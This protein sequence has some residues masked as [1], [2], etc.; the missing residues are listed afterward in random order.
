MKP[1]EIVDRLFEADKSIRYVAVVGPAP[2][3]ELLESRMRE[4]LKS[5]TE[6]KTDRDFVGII[7][8]V[9]LGAS[10]RLEKDLGEVILCTMRYEKATLAF[11]RLKEYI[12]TLGLEP[13]VYVLPIVQRIK[14]ELEPSH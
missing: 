12:V 3:Y 2:N 4:G 8:V 1:S 9:M 5:L 6:E 10:E 14:S 11:F 7:P 13:G